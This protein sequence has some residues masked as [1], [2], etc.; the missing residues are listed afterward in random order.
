LIADSTSKRPR[1]KSGADP[2]ASRCSPRGTAAVSD[3]A[4]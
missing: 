3:H 4:S 2:A 1:G